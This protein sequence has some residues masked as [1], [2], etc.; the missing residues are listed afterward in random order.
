MFEPGY[1]LCRQTVTLYHPDAAAGKV[2]R[3]VVTGAFLDRRWRENATETGRQAAGSFLLVIPGKSAAYGTDYTLAP[4]DRLL[5]GEGPE[6]QWR[7]W[8][9]FVPAAVAGLC[10][11]QYVDPKTL[12]GTPCHLEAGGWWTRSGSGAHSLTN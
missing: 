10:C 5:E 6:V 1:G 12:G 9:G 2:V 11:V 7:D 3:R 8:A 4:G